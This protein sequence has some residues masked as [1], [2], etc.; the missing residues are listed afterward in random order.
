MCFFVI[1]LNEG[2]KIKEIIWL[3]K[4]NLDFEKAKATPHWDRIEFIDAGISEDWMEH[5]APR[6]RIIKTHL[7]LKFLPADFNKQAKVRRI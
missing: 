3:M 7:P 2:L 4:H 6:P 5:S 1:F